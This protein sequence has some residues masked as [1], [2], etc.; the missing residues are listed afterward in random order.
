VRN[1]VVDAYK[2]IMSMPV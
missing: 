1:K 2:E